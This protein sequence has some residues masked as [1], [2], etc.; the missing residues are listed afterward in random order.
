[1]KITTGLL[2]VATLTTLTA[3]TSMKVDSEQNPDFDFSGVETYEW[4]QP[5]AKILDE[6]DTIL[7]GNMQMALNNELSARGWKQVLDSDQADIQVVYY[8]KLAEHEEYTTPPSEGEPRL[9]GGGFTF[10]NDSGKWG[11]SDQSPDLNVYTVE[12]GTL[13]LLVYDTRN[14]EKA[15]S[16]T[17]QTKL[18]RS[19]PQEKQKEHL[20]RIARK[21]TTRIP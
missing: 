14:N 15:W 9:T 20:R 16:G 4:V 12:I 17:L 1:M 18:N 11:Y 19:M 6:E 10:N 7:N 21:I 8:I 5:P 2:F 3:C 13:S